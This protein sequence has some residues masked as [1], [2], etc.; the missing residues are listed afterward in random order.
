MKAVGKALNSQLFMP[1]RPKKSTQG[2]IR[3]QKRGLPRE[4]TW[5]YRRSTS[6]RCADTHMLGPL[7]E[8]VRYVMCPVTNL[9]SFKGR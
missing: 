2:C 8:N 7:R 1:L 4:K 5:I 9:G 3:R 6:A